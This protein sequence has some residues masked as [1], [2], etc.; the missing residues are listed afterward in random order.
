MDGLG[1]LIITP[2]RELAYQIFAVLGNIGKHHDFSAG[3]IIGQYPRPDRKGGGPTEGA[4]MGRGP[5]HR[6]RTV[7]L[8]SDLAFVGIR[9]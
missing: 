9:G 7:N 5:V 8:V 6:A 3:L 2:T 4:V 1:A